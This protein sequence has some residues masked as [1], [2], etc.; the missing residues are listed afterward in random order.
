MSDVGDSYEFVD[1]A[2]GEVEAA[3][4]VDSGCASDS[5]GC[6]VECGS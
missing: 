4:Y 2:V 1:W 3:S 6:V 5:V